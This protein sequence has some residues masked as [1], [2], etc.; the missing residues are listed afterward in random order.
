KMTNT[1][2]VDDA[3]T[4][5]DTNQDGVIDKDEFRN[6]KEKSEGVTST[7]Y[8]TTTLGVN[9]YGNT[10]IR[11]DLYG[12]T[13]IRDD[14]YGS[15]TIR[16]DRY[17]Y[18]VNGYNDLSYTADKYTTRGTTLATRDLI[19]QTAIVTSCSEETSRYLEKY[20]NNIYIDSNPQIIRRTTTENPVTYEQ[21]VLV[22]Y[23]QPPPLPPP[24]VMRIIVNKFNFT[25]LCLISATYY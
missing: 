6:M 7:P 25:Y 15:T 2:C 11:D 20:A 12:S 16:D 13:T 19:N 4:Q 14:L 10:T 3:F 22:R 1:D 23:L 18:N 17:K 24:E 9:R 21:R 8:E 5:I